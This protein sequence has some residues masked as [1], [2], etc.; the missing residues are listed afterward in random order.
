MEK[1]HTESSAYAICN[2]SLYGSVEELK[3]AGIIPAHVLTAKDY[4]WDQCISDQMNRYGDMETAKKV[5]GNIKA[6]Y[7]AVPATSSTK[8]KF[9]VK[10]FLLDSSININK[11]GV[12]PDSIDRNINSFIGKPLLLYINQ[13]GQFDH[14]S[15]PDNENLSHWL[16]YQ[17]TYK[18]GTVIDISTKAN[19]TTG[20]NA[21]YA[22]IEVSNKDL[23]QSLRDNKVP[24]YVSPAIAEFVNNPIKSGT[25]RLAD[26]SELAENWHGVHIAIVNEPAFGIKKAVINE[27]CGGDEKGC[28]LQ[29]RKASIQKYGLGNCGFCV[30]KALTTYANLQQLTKYRQHSAASNSSN[31][32]N[33][34]HPANT[35]TNGRKMSTLEPAETSTTAETNKVEVVEQKSAPLTQQPVQQQQPT[36]PQT[37]QV[38]RQPVATPAGSY[39]IP[40]L[41]Q[42]ISQLEQ[43]V[44]LRD[45]KIEELSSVN[46]TFG[47]RVAALEMERRR[48]K[49]E[50]IITG[51]VIRD[52]KARLDKINYFTSSSIPIE[53][54]DAL[55]KDVK[56]AIKKASVNQPRGRVPY[57]GASLGNSSIASLG[58]QN[59]PAVTVDEDTGL[60]PLQ[61]QLAVLRG[62]P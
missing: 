18:V 17:E 4:P 2:T 20:N 43:T 55:Y 21:Y 50:R 39:S 22:I 57:V 31:V 48:E 47:E 35:T 42:K 44:Q 10:A 16:S 5:C 58:Y 1:G 19:P 46:N 25:V 3:T 45:I 12:T 14:P 59:S 13:H 7:G 8:D 33:T 52:Q 56:V 53:E 24:L 26:G 9:Y 28:L 41:L 23:E 30:K 40:D 36:I 27:T 51:D 61:K 32:V 62:G 29:L 34:S 11:W 54:I 60:T 15:P 37:V 6:K 49:I 38:N